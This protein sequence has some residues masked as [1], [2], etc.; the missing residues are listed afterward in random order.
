MFQDDKIKVKIV[1]LPI[2][3]KGELVLDYKNTES[4]TLSLYMLLET[5]KTKQRVDTLEYRINGIKVIGEQ[6]TA[7]AGLST[8]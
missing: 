1:G 4:L 7:I 8:G 6:A 5:L 2:N 3:K